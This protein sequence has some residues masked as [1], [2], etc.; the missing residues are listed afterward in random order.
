MVFKVW[1]HMEVVEACKVSI[2]HF[3][4]RLYEVGFLLLMYQRAHPCEI[5][6]K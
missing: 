5:S 6:Y 1:M 4:S 3:P 2:G